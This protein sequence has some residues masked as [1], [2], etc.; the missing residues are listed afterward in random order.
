VLDPREESLR[1]SVGRIRATGEEATIR[2]IEIRRGPKQAI[3]IV[4]AAPQPSAAFTTEEVKR[5]FR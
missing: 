4:I 3:E 2:H 5:F 1:Q